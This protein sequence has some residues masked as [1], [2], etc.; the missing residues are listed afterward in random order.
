MTDRNFTC[1][2]ELKPTSAALAP[3]T[4]SG[5]LPSRCVNI[6]IEISAHKPTAY[7]SSIY[8]WQ[9]DIKYSTQRMSRDYVW[10]NLPL[11]E[12][13][14][15]IGQNG[16]LQVAIDSAMTGSTILLEPGTYSENLY[17]TKPLHLIAYGGAEETHMF[18]EISITA[19]DVTLQ[20]MTFYPPVKSF[21]TVTVYNSSVSIINCRF[22]DS[23]ESTAL[24][25]P[26]PT[27][28]IDC[29]HCPHL[30]VINNDFYRW[31]YAI[32]LKDAKNSVIQ[33][34]TF[35]SCQTAI[36]IVAGGSIRVIG[37]LF[38]DN[39]LALESSTTVQTDELLNTNVFAGN[40]IPLFYQGKVFFYSDLHRDN[41]YSDHVNVSQRFF[42]SVQCNMTVDPSHKTCLSIGSPH[43]TLGM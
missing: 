43:F 36:S 7:Y 3:V 2:I 21:S 37:N 5:H 38:R 8:S 32:V 23:L 15:R 4:R 18:G 42:I 27:I 33:T 6:T 35:R 28:A 25:L 9:L 13:S 39:V 11:L 34:N 20:G 29:E 17:I 24:Y 16:S 22:I 10:R 41:Q 26:R 1:K 31:K 12:G 14:V 30:A 19:Q 40:V